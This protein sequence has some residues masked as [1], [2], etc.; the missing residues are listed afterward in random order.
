M[1]NF[2]P[3]YNLSKPLV[4]E[5][6]DVGVPNSNSDTLDAAIKAIAD[7]VTALEAV[8][9]IYADKITASAGWT[10]NSQQLLKL[11]RIIIVHFQ[12][13]RTG[14]AINAPADGNLVNTEMG[15]VPAGYRP[16][17]TARAGWATTTTGR[18]SGGYLSETG[19]LVI[20]WTMPSQ[21]VATNDV[22]T[23]SCTYLQGN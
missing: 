10:V 18:G 7:R 19:S 23:G 20:A 17:G 1:P 9:T 12:F 13:T 22:I 2:T 15:T 11:G 16:G 4:T 5:L 3:N 14:A 6:Y 21:D 8:P